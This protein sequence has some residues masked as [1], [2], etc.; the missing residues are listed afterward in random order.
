MAGDSARLIMVFGSDAYEPEPLLVGIR[1]LTGDVPLIGCST[2]GEITPA[3]P[4]DATL[5]VLVLGGPGFTVATAESSLLRGPREAGEEVAGAL[6]EVDAPHKV[7]MILPD[8]ASI[9]HQDIVRGAH[10][11]A[12]AEISVVGGFAAEG[13]LRLHR[14]FQLKDGGVRQQTVVAAAIGSTGPFG[15]G[16]RHGWRPVGE[17][18]TVSWDATGRI[19][20][21]DDEPALDAYL[22]RLNA[23]EE[24]YSDPYEFD[25]FKQMRMIGLMR[26]DGY[27]VIR[28]LRE[29]NFEDRTLGVQAID[30]AEDGLVR[31]VEGDPASLLD[32]AAAACSEA[33]DGIGGPPLGFVAFDCSSRKFVLGRDR[34]TEVDRIVALSAGAPVAGFYSYGEIATGHGPDGYH[35]GT[36]VVLALG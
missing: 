6:R 3:G 29:A 17:P 34:G 25:H 1:S 14:P 32:A 9:N 21:L 8:G 33:L 12:G 28:G 35:H 7:L 19:S 23:P 36:L 22:S 20:R 4:A 11:Q 18:M 5:V 10:S 31:V 26:G 15:I 2:A 27:E 16:V 30:N 24:A 13:G